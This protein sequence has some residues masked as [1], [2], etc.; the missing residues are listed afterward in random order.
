MVVPVGQRSGAQEL[1]FVHRD[2]RGSV[3]QRHILPV[4]F[5]PLIGR[6]E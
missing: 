1:V 4:T 5:V 3:Q 2:S 6:S